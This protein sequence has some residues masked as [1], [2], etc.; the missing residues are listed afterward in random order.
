M[1]RNF[2]K[3]FKIIFINFY[4]N[5]I[6]VYFVRYRKLKNRV[7]A[8]TSRDRKKAKLD[9][10]ED[11]VTSLVE[12]KEM[13]MEECTALRSQNESLLSEIKRLRRERD[14]LKTKRELCTMC[15]GR[16]DCSVPSTGSA[17]SQINPLLQGGTIQLAL[18]PKQTHVSTI[19]LKIL[20]LF[21]LSKNCLETSKTTITS[22]DSNSLQKVFCE[23]LPPE[24]KQILANQMNM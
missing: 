9:Q 22:T 11:T 15:Q 2:V 5:L 20:T 6:T 1:L 19:L 16:V 17:E 3:K 8:Q 7:A 14:E 12:S 4:V 13:I 21:L 10:L 18:S 24:L 23:K